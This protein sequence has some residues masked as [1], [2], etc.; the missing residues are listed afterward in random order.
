MLP[1]RA[2]S[3]CCIPVLLLLFAGSGATQELTKEQSPKNNTS[4]A[5]EMTTLPEMIVTEQPEQ[6]YT[7]KQAT[8]ATKTDTPIEQI[9]QSIQIVPRAVME[10][11]HNLSVAE[12]VRNVSG[13]QATNT[14]QTP[15]YE[16]TYIRGFPAEQWLDGFT[17]YYNAGNRDSLV[18]VE[19]VEVLKG[20]GTLYGG[21]SGA[22]LGG[23]VNVISKMP[24]DTFFSR[25]GATFG[26]HSFLQPYFDVNAPLTKNGMVLFRMTGEYTSSDSFIDTIKTD[27]YSLHPTLT[28]TNKTGTTLTIQG[29]IS[30]WRQQEYQGLPATG[31][32]A[33]AFHLDRDLF[34]GPKNMPRSFS[35]VSSV[36]ARLEHEFNSILSAN[37]QARWSGTEFKELAQNFIGAGFDFAG[38]RPAVAPS[39][40]S[41]LN[42]ELG[43]KQTEGTVNANLVAKWSFGKTKHTFLIGYDYSRISDKGN[44]FA[45]FNDL[46]TL[47]LVDLTN[48]VFPAYV[49]PGPGEALANVVVDGD[50]HYTTQ[51]GSLQVQSTL[52]ERVHF[53][54]GVRIANLQIDSVSPAFAR[55][56]KTDQTK[57]LP[58]VGAVV[59]LYKGLS[60][61]AG[62]GEGMKG[63]PFVFYGGT[64]KPEE[65]NQK[66]AGIRFHLPHG[67]SGSAA[68]FE[69]ERSGVPIFIDVASQP[70]GK[71]RSRGFDI[72]LVWEPFS[73]WQMLANYAFVD[74]AL[75]KDIPG[76]A[77]AG[78]HLNIVP[79]HSGRFWLHYRF[80]APL[81]SGWSIGSG[82][83]ASSGAFVD[84]ANQFRA[85]SYFTFDSK[86]AYENE[87]FA[88]LFSVKNLT[89]EKY[90]V[91]FVYYG[92]RVA[93]GDERAVY[94]AVTVKF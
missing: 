93:P 81:L 50:N 86:I 82:V 8:T 56:D 13:V 11:Q 52:W 37:V 24:T 70:V 68:V 66:E 43:Q 51:G 79:E 34:V 74:A 49:R 48:P 71:Q 92:G 38:N 1:K 2:C 36:T 22:P 30:D 16:S 64:P 87:Y 63:N 19:R 45:N 94:G 12:A 7:V 89:G 41:L 46:L 3:A 29:R 73:N 35:W 84:L 28:L 55:K 90:F 40:W 44:M 58:R 77:T 85:D 27:R 67:L 69:I 32:I 17:T 31:T 47:G 59:D 25:V 23:V 80:N 39:N 72:D 54:G 5:N 65:S 33:G 88:A 91:P 15:A 14:L 4:S 10:D 26:S 53:L 20:P 6:T 18:N 42:L 21:G 62:Y 61:F 78:K 60:L 75:T 57:A 83:Y 76:T 9:P